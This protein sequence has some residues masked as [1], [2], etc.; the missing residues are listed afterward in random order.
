MLIMQPIDCSCIDLAAKIYA[1]WTSPAM[2][3][4]FE[5][6]LVESCTPGSRISVVGIYMVL[7][8]KAVGTIS[9]QMGSVLLANSVSPLSHDCESAI[10][11]IDIRY[12]PPPMHLTSTYKQQLC[13]RAHHTKAV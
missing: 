12:W 10:E 1:R 5:D 9:G 13:K 11:T 4:F 8:P 3:V 7:P 2:Q 6:D